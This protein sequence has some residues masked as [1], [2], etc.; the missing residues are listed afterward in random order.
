MIP[1]LVALY[2][3]AAEGRRNSYEYMERLLAARRAEPQ[4]DLASHVASAESSK[5]ELSDADRIGI[6]RLVMEAR[7]GHDNRLDR[8]RARGLQSAPGTMGVAAR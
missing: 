7:R 1:E 6:L 2:G 4:E 5:G 8:Y 3:T